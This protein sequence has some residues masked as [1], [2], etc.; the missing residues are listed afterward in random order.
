MPPHPAVVCDSVATEVYFVEPDPIAP[1]GF[2]AL[3]HFPMGHPPRMHETVTLPDAVG[4]QPRLY[5]VC[6]VIHH[7]PRTPQVF[8]EDRRPLASYACTCVVRQNVT[9]ADIARVVFK[10]CQSDLSSNPTHS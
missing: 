10:L 7:M 5:K 3:G 2:R 8:S 6:E 4:A 1:S 9:D